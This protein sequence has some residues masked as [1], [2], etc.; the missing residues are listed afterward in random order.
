MSQIKFVKKGFIM[1]LAITLGA[2]AF[3]TVTVPVAFPELKDAWYCFKDQ[4]GNVAVAE[5]MEKITPWMTKELSVEH[6]TT[7]PIG[8]KVHFS[9]ESTIII[10]EGYNTHVQSDSSDKI[11]YFTIIGK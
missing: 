11:W 1:S 9:D 6:A 8:T 2:L 10:H 7:L 4:Q 3:A 5:N